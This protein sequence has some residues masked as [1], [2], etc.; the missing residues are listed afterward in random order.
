MGWRGGEGRGGGGA[1][2]K[3]SDKTKRGKKWKRKRTAKE[4]ETSSWKWKVVICKM[5]ESA[6]LFTFNAIPRGRKY[7]LRLFSYRCSDASALFNYNH[8]ELF[9]GELNYID[10]R[11]GC[12]PWKTL[13]IYLLLLLFFYFWK[14]IHFPPSV[15]FSL[16]LL[17]LLASSFIHLLFLFFPLSLFFIIFF[18]E[19]YGD[20]DPISR[21]SFFLMIFI[22]VTLMSHLVSVRISF[23]W[24]CFCQS[25]NNPN[26]VTRRFA[27]EWRLLQTIFH[28][29][30]V[31]LKDFCAV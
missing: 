14:K 22:S 17:L 4:N 12:W 21:G 8:I 18:Y 30:D 6:G 19:F 2:A 10:C 9:R 11:G 23:A 15:F 1:E 5:T 28:V 24:C 27:R 31:D 16:L 20:V 3:A 26:I 25:W 13:A 7:C 29:L